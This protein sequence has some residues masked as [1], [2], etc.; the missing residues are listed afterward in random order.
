M[1]TQSKYL[2]SLLSTS[3]FIAGCYGDVEGNSATASADLFPPPEIIEELPI[4]PTQAHPL[5]ELKTL[6]RD[7]SFI[8]LYY[9]DSNLLVG[10]R[11]RAMLESSLHFVELSVDEIR[12]VVQDKTIIATVGVRTK[13]FSIDKLQNIADL[14]FVLKPIAIFLDMAL[15]PGVD[16]ANVEYLMLNGALSELDPH[17]LLLPPVAAAEMEM[18]NQGEF[19]GLGIEI[20]IQEG[21]LTVKQPIEGT[22][23]WD[24]G[25]KADD[26]I[27]R[28]EE[29]S[30]IN[31]DL[32]EA[33]SMLRGVVGT[34]VTIMVMRT[35]W[36]AAKP[37]TIV[38]GR[39]KI[40]PVKGE[41]LDGNIG[42]IKIQS[43]HQNVDTDMDAFLEQMSKQSKTGL[44]GLVIDL[45]NNPGGYLN[46]AI[47][48][49]DRFLH[50]GVIVSTVEGAK[51]EREE[52]RAKPAGT[53]SDIPIAVLVNGNSA[54][55]SEIVA[56]ALRNQGR[57]IIIGERSF[58][59]GSVQHLYNNPDASRLKLTVAQYLTPGDQSIQSVGIPPDVLLQ[60]SVIRPE[61]TEDKSLVSL[62]WREWTSREA[63]LDGHLNNDTILQ[64]ET[65]F[66]VR[67]VLEDHKGADRVDPKKDWEVE[68]ARK[69]LL[70]TKGNDRGAAILA[71][72]KIVDNIQPL[73]EQKIQQSFAVLDID[74]H[75]GVNHIDKAKEDIQLTMVM[76][77]N[78]AGVLQAGDNEKV[79]FQLQN[80][81]DRDYHQLSLVTTSV[82]PSLEHRELYIGY[83]PKGTS[84]EKSIEVELPRGY[85]DEEGE[86]QVELRD[87]QHTLYSQ[88]MMYKTKAVDKPR[89]SIQMS[90]FDGGA[91]GKGNGNG[92]VEVGEN[93]VLQVSVTNVGA[94][95]SIESYVRL[96]NRSKKHVDLLQGTL[97]VGEWLHAETQESC[98]AQT[99]NC[100]RILRAGTTY[101]GE[102]ELNVRSMPEDQDFWNLELLV[103]SNR[104]YDYN[105]TIL[106]GFSEYFQIKQDVQLSTTKPWSNVVLEQ[107]NIVVEKTEVTDSVL[108]LTG[109]VEDTSGLMDII[110]FT[111]E[112]KV[113]YKGES[114]VVGKVP[115]SVDIPLEEG[116]NPLYIL[117]KDNTDIHS[118][119]YLHFWQQ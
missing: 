99:E 45:R 48:V 39:I 66:Q 88:T 55:A 59:K 25:L 23:A 53:I 86:V 108:S 77:K 62:Y 79:F 54:S 24:A 21:Q 58:G 89:Y 113:Y 84:I 9:V 8:N 57:A 56:G 16:R 67:Y 70:E 117:A 100:V 29:T 4:T 101:T 97:E 47:R 33:V 12:F 87:M 90:M 15:D 19:G 50:N 71:A 17:S 112:N 78:K 11:L 98:A 44:R 60:P 109:Y 1:Q 31:M 2:V 81:S 49:S 27:V 74:W 95:D 85:G 37:F 13:S 72:K 41:L 43:F 7:F 26:K 92:K 94:G 115:F 104:S 36:T 106:G 110:M 61:S 20:N 64:G 18:D 28:I 30:T 75:G 118:S 40:D 34:P 32:D 114:A 91:F 52:N 107:P 105:T 93:I 10:E 5:R 82:N 73:E 119:L 102:L 69:V 63:D 3:I 96:K 68:F 76:G 116:S 65:R 42:Y 6:E 22:P 111:G 83:L 103:G 35:G 80:T 38:R 46:Q 14:L 51:R